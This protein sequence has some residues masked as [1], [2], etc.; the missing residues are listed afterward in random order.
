LDADILIPRKLYNQGVRVLHERNGRELSVWV[1]TPTAPLNF[2]SGSVMTFRIPMKTDVAVTNSSGS[3]AVEGLTPS[4]INLEVSS[5]KIRLKD[6]TARL[7]VKSSSG[8]I[9]IEA[10]D[11][12]KNISSSSGTITVS[13]SDGDI[14]A[15][16]SSGKHD[17][18]KIIGSIAA[19]SSSGKI[20]VSDSEGTVELRSSS[21][22]LGGSALSITGNSAFQT[23][24]GSI[25]IDFSND[26]DDF[27]FK[28]ES[29]SGMITVAGIRAK[30][31]V[32]TGSGK[33]QITGIS[34][35]G[36]QK[37]Q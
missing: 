23:T 32:A 12:I 22:S 34:T 24:S 10:Y 6:I 8:S 13:D 3:V 9:E 30:G 18:R 21:G 14:A 31:D 20:M 7:D 15:D 28:L 27:T 4:R 29:S 35:S 1:E 17:Y 36:S 25:N 19:H 26:I 5:G 11:G 37:Y 2:T 33:I 16:S